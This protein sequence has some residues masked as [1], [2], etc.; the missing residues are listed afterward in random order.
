MDNDVI[1]SPIAVEVYRQ[2]VSMLVAV[3]KRM[4]MF[5]LAREFRAMH[6]LPLADTAHEGAM[7]QLG[8]SQRASD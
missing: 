2:D 4:T 7:K 8:L 3:L 1:Q 5:V 6:P